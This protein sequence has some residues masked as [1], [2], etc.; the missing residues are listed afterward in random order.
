M[1]VWVPMYSAPTLQLNYCGSRNR[2]CWLCQRG[3]PLVNLKRWVI[4]AVF[5]TSRLMCPVNKLG[6][7]R[8]QRLHKYDHLSALKHF[9]SKGL[10]QPILVAWRENVTQRGV[11]S[12]YRVSVTHRDERGG[13]GC[14]FWS[15]RAASRVTQ[16]MN[17]PL[18]STSPKAKR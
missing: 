17:E 4:E 9:S 2:V 6:I 14:K 15:K 8:A 18:V 7:I 12:E 1:L 13:A 3:L 16:C 10:K 11:K 5:S